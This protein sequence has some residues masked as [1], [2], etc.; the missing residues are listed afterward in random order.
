[1]KTFNSPDYRIKP[2]LPDHRRTLYWSPNV[3]T[4]IEGKAKVEF[5]NNAT[6]R[7]IEISAEGIAEDGTVLL[8]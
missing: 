4:N 5:Y 7:Q 8:Y 1:V 2:A 6:C 3:Y